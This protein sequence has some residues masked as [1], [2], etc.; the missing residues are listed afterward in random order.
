MRQLIWICVA[1]YALAMAGV[2]FAAHRIVANFGV[3]GGLVTIAAMLTTAVYFDRRR[4]SPQGAAPV[5]ML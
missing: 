4:R 3:L 1:L 5:R 2:S